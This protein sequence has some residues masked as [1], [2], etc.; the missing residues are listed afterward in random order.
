MLESDQSAHT[1]TH[2]YMYSQPLH[3]PLLT[4]IRKL[5]S[6]PISAKL[7]A[8][9]SFSNAHDVIIWMILGLGPARGVYPV[10][11]KTDPIGNGHV[12]RSKIHV[13]AP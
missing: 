3:T 12:T 6:R 9:V 10:M 5:F 7:R 8:R 1:R 13:V 4:K 2:S 11:A